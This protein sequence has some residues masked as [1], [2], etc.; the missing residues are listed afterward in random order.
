MDAIGKR[1]KKCYI[2][3]HSYC[4]L[5]EIVSPATEPWRAL[6]LQAPTRGTFEG[7]NVLLLLGRLDY[8]IVAIPIDRQ[9]DAVWR[10]RNDREYVVPPP[11]N[12]VPASCRF[13]DKRALQMQW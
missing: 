12:E 8:C 13:V 6:R 1:Q 9:A 10:D 7:Y 2:E 4:N 5:E 3:R 11:Y